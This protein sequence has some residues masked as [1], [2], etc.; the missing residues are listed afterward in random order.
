MIVT[1]GGTP[2]KLGIPGEAGVRRAR[3]SPTAR[4]ATAPS[5]AIS[6][7]PSSAAA[8]RPSRRPTSSRATPRRCTSSIGATS[9]R[10]SKILQERLFANP[11][12]RS[13][14]EHGRRGGRSATS[15]G[16]MKGLALRNVET[17]SRR[18]R[19]TRR[20][21]S[22]SSASGRTP[23][24]S[25]ATSTTIEMGYIVTD[26]HDADVDPRTVRRRR[27]ALAAHAAGDH[28]RRRRDDRGDRRGEVPQGA[29]RGRADAVDPIGSG[30]YA[31]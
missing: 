27:P 19:S 24:S 21:A 17:D 6:A 20:A 28:R 29:R 4:S 5:S 9:F 30:G 2:I 16:S 15:R 22:C 11:E 31:V 12:D 8:T 23:G 13:R 3:A 7:S 1:A 26:A 10:A 14:L 18:A 25:T